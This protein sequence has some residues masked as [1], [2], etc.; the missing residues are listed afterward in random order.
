M[1]S[2]D[3]GHDDGGKDFGHAASLGLFG[4]GIAALCGSIAMLCICCRLNGKVPLTS[5]MDLKSI[6]NKIQN[7]ASSDNPVITEAVVTNV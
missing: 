2:S 7:T 1:A 4:A 5:K 6:D 3:N